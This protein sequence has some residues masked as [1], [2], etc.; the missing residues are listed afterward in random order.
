MRFGILGPLEVWGAGG[1]LEIRGAKRRALLAHLLVRAGAPERVDQ[2]VEAV[3]PGD[4]AVGATDTVRTYVSQ[5][6][7]VFA[8]EKGGPN[9]HTGP[10]GYRLDLEPDH[11]DALRLESALAEAA[12]A[13]DPANRLALLHEAHSLRRGIVLGEFAGA[14]WADQAAARWDRLL[15]VASEQ[16]A[17]ALLDA[18][19]DRDALLLLD[20]LVASYPM[21]ER[22]RAQLALARYR[23][24]DQIEALAALRDG[25]R[26][27]AEELGIEPGVELLDL[28]SRILRRDD[29]LMTSHTRPEAHSAASEALPLGT[30][31]FLLT[32][33]VHS[34]S[35]WDNHPHEM[36]R[37]LARHETIIEETVREH[38]GRLIKSRGEGDATLSVFERATD[39][40]STALDL[41]GAFRRE[42]WPGGLTLGTRVALHTG[43]AHLRN[44]D[45]YGGAVNRTARIRG[46]AS[47][48]QVLCSQT[49]AS[50]VADLL[51]AEV[52]LED[53]GSHALRG[54]RRNE[55]VYSITTRRAGRAST[56]GY[57]LASVDDDPAGIAIAPPAFLERGAAFV[58]RTASTAR[59]LGAWRETCSGHPATALVTGEPGIGKTRLVAELA[60]HAYSDGA[61]VI[62]GQ[63]D[64][65]GGAPFHPWVYALRTLF[66]HWPP[67]AA[68]SELD[69]C[70]PI[71]TLLPELRE[72]FPAVNAWVGSAEAD[73]WIVFDAVARLLTRVARRQLLVVVIDDLQWADDPSALLFRHLAR[74]GESVPL[75]LVGT[76]RE[77][78]VAQRPRLGEVLADLARQPMLVRIALDGIDRAGALTLVAD[79]SSDTLP[80][81]TAAAVHEITHGNPF[82]VHQVVAHLLESGVSEVD[83]TEWP[84]PLPVA[85]RDLINQRVSLLNGDAA[86]L[87]VGAAVTGMRWELTVVAR[88]ASIERTTALDLLEEALDSGLV[89]ECSEAGWFE[90]QHA[91]VRAAFIDRAGRLKRAR[92]HARVAEAIEA[93]HHGDVDAQLSALAHHWF[94]A[95]HYFETGPAVHYGLRAAEV[96]CSS[97]AW[98]ESERHCLRVLA[99]VDAGAGSVADRWHATTLLARARGALGNCHEQLTLAAAACEIARTLD[100]PGRFGRA[101]LLLEPREAIVAAPTPIEPLLAEAISRLDGVDSPELALVL[102]AHIAHIVETGVCHDA[103]EYIEERTDEALAMADRIGDEQTALD[104]CIRLGRMRTG[105]PGASRTLALAERADRLLQ[106]RWDSTAYESMLSMLCEAFSRLGHRAGLV[107]ALRRRAEL[108]ERFASLP[109]SPWFAFIDGLLPMI[110]GRCDDAMSFT[111]D[112]REQC[113]DRESLHA[114]VV[115]RTTRIAWLRGNE[116]VV[117]R[118]IERSMPFEPYFPQLTAFRA[119]TYA[120]QGRAHDAERLVEELLDASGNRLQWNGSRPRVLHDLA[121]AIGLLDNPALATALEPLLA[122]YTGELLCSYLITVDGAATTSLGILDTVL[123]RYTNAEANFAAG[124]ALE[125]EFGAVGP[126][127][128]TRVWWALARAKRG[129]TDEM[130]DQLLTD[131]ERIAARCGIGRVSSLAHRHAARRARGS[132]TPGTQTP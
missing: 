14:P 82:F 118:R 52:V 75:L 100:D 17:D 83:A 40:I 21:N 81:E 24:G 91:L 60:S 35:L 26:V 125:E 2:I 92:Q 129:A 54:L 12:S 30:V 28:E 101:A 74:H 29:S 25:R 107:D 79:L 22:F 32:D 132:K 115:D 5:L 105:L 16:Y 84:A 89:Q 127:A 44:R 20:G 34:T 41:Q 43:E 102:A 116:D 70:E 120:E 8:L 39:A 65:Y 130:S 109:R 77:D 62:G 63:C 119:L 45:Y 33:I 15:V 13:G 1:L 19:C 128:T 98:E 31:T 110:D 66:E 48:G 50:I 76:Y 27:L 103:L 124:L 59:L 37:A 90:F 42:D 38:G 55:R 18:S 108:A 93:V 106:R 56:G 126:A 99:L 122:P 4:A 3:W 67:S 72:M 61:I 94:E 64:Q 114:A 9:L 71:V 88:A 7:K 58:S 86:S 6:R 104:V 49:T 113:G 23:C 36:T 123:G 69:G 131:A 87:L 51:D 96:A 117:T 46:L 47:G 68:R 80:S 11:L 97:W 85:V 78:A 111:Q 53:L 73:R 112:A 57:P 95:A 121:E 10:D